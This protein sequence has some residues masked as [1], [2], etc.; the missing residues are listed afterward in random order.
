L[1]PNKTMRMGEGQKRER[2]REREEETVNRSK[3]GDGKDRG[4]VRTW[5]MGI[6]EVWAANEKKNK[7]EM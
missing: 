7:Q 5:I 1:F 2:E 6:V 3:R 4:G